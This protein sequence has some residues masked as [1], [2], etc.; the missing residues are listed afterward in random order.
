MCIFSIVNVLR[1]KPKITLEIKNQT[2]L[3]YSYLPGQQPLQNPSEQS[4]NPNPNFFPFAWYSGTVP[5]SR[6]FSYSLSFSPQSKA[7]ELAS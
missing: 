5:P 1:L 2:P 3:V 4:G 7:S 6:T